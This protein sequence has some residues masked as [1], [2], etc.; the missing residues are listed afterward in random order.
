MYNNTTRC[1]Y[2]DK[3]LNKLHRLE[4]V[5]I[6]IIYNPVLDTAQEVIENNT[7]QDKTTVYDTVSYMTLHFLCFDKFISL[8]L[9]LW[10]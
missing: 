7:Q 9:K 5:I 4:E 10:H 3:K 1:K 8:P 2:T 6:C